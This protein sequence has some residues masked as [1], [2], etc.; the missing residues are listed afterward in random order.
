MGLKV[1]EV[2]LEKY[3]PRWHQMFARELDELWDYFGD[4][5]IRISHIGSTAV[6][7]LEAKPIIDIAVAVNDLDDFNE[8]SHKFTSNPEYSIK[9]DF[10]ND[11]ILIRKGGKLN[12]QFYIHVMDVDSKRYKDAIFFRD[13]LL[14]DEKICGDYRNLKHMLSKK[15]PHNRKK[16]TASKAD[17]IENTLDVIWAR[18]TLLPI[19]VV[20]G[21]A[22]I[23]TAIAIWA[24]F[25]LPQDTA[26]FGVSVILMARV[27]L[28]FS[29]IVAIAMIIA[30]IVLSVRY[31][32]A[33]KAYDQI[34]EKVNKAIA[35][36]TQKK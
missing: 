3:N 16:Y 36:E 29:G 32:R 23:T 5:A 10:D 7:G 9:E 25:N 4:T 11:E 21:I 15:Y 33:K 20:G 12:R 2:R 34:V 6:D 26:F 19:M 24:L 18:S 1:G 13:T 17:F 28:F 35:K 8:V 27:A 31:F 30:T 14:R 22:I